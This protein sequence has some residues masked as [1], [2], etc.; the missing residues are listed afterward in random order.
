MAANVI[1]K[2]TILVDNVLRYPPSGLKVIVVGSGPGGLLAAIECWR[3]GHEVEVLEKS[4]EFSS[5]GV[6]ILG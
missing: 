6:Y 1:S 4:P 2:E 5:I 3:K